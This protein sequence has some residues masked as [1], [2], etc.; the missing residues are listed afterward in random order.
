MKKSAI[1][2]FVVLFSLATAA[3][4]R[5]PCAAIELV[6]NLSVDAACSVSKSRLIRS[7]L[8]D[9]EFFFDLEFLPAEVR[10]N[11]CFTIVDPGAGGGSVPATITDEK[12]GIMVDVRVSGMAGLT[13]N[14]YGAFGAPPLPL[15]FT[16]ASVLSLTRDGKHI[17]S[18][19]TRDA[20]TNFADGNVAARLSV[21]AG[22]GKLKDVVGYIDEYGQ[23]FDEDHPAEAVGRLCGKRFVHYLRGVE[24]Y[25]DYYEDKDDEDDD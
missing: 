23:E 8:P 12:T 10:E 20:G 24:D 11:S 19:A 2:H 3:A 5:T 16:A 17:G 4:A 21:A 18:V 15:S 7:N 13:W 9:Q 1:L 14:E 6:F 25:D 22:T